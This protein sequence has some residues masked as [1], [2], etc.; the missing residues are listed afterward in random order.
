VSATVVVSMVFKLQK[1]LLY[2]IVERMMSTGHNPHL[3]HH[4]SFS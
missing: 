2:L 3:T 4:L 1:L